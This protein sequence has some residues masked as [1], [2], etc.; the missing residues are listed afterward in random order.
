M[1]KLVFAILFAAAALPL[2]AQ[3]TSHGCVAITVGSPQKNGGKFDASFS[4]TEVVDV[5]FS[6]VFTPGVAQ[7]YSGDHLV[8]FR[9]LGPRGHLYQSMTIPFT[10]DA[11]NGRKVVVTGYPA[12]LQTK[13]LAPVQYSG[14]QHMYVSATL[15]VAATS[16][17]SNGLYGTWTAQAYVDGDPLAC[18]QPARFQITP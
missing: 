9:I 13:S 12:P 5:E 16:I 6:I 2:A 18:S 8:E 4:A 17:V 14:A 7:R 10:A 15:P 11:T 3:S 1:K